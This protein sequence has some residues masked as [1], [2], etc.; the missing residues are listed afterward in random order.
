MEW[1]KKAWQN[2][3]SSTPRWARRIGNAL[4]AVGVTISATS[5]FMAHEKIAIGAGISACVGRFL[6]EFFHEDETHS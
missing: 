5:A 1:I 6:V 2:L 4:S 3:D